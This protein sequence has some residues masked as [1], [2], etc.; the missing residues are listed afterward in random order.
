MCTCRE[1]RHTCPR[2]GSGSRGP[3]LGLTCQK[4]IYSGVRGCVYPGCQ[5]SHTHTGR[6]RWS[7]AR[8]WHVRGC[9]GDWMGCNTCLLSYLGQLS[10]VALVCI[11]V[12]KY[13]FTPPLFPLPPL[14]IVGLK[15]HLCFRINNVCQVTFVPIL[16]L[17]QRAFFVE[18]VYLPHAPWMNLCVSKVDRGTKLYN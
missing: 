9:V 13:N 4:L 12:E 2:R 15:L 16:C 10:L 18:R 6:R 14:Y 5:K 3:V 17:C 8:N 11:K 7:P 1:R